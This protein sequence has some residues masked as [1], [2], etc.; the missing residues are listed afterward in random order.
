MATAPANIIH[1]LPGCV[2]QGNTRDEALVNIRDAIA[3]YLVSLKKHDE[4]V[5]PPISEDIV[6]VSA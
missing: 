3:G 4:P 6:E 5:P 1:K 2:S